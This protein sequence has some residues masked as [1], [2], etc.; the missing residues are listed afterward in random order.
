MAVAELIKK[1][2]EISKDV[3]ATQENLEKV[4]CD[5]Q[6]DEISENTENSNSNEEINT[7][8]CDVDE[9]PTNNISEDLG[10]D[11]KGAEVVENDNKLT[12]EEQNA[13][14][15][16]IK[17]EI[18]NAVAHDSSNVAD[19]FENEN[20]IVTNENNSRIGRDEPFEF[21][22]R[23]LTESS[24][25]WDHNAWDNVEWGEDQVKEAQAKIELQ[26]E[27]PVSDFDKA[28]FNKNPARY[29]DI[30]YKNNKE[31]FFKDRKWLQIEF[32]SLYAATKKD[33][34][35]VTIFEIGCGAGNTFFPI[36]TENENEHLRIIAAD[37]APKAVELVKSSEQ[38]NP[39]YGHAAVWDLA[40][41]DGALPD[42]VEEHS[43][44]IAV[45]IFVF[46]ALAPNQWQQA[47]D[48]L[49][50]VLKPGGK[51]LFRDYGRYDLAQVRFKKNRLLDDN[52]YVRGDGT[53]VYFFTEEE[54]RE[55]FT[56][57]YFIEN[58]IGT[59]RRLL[60]NRKRQLKMYR[61]WLQAVFEVP[62]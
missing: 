3:E 14:A 53:R 4:V 37:F 55:I 23:Q 39:K 9:V 62:E 13:M 44:D 36:L 5:E 57:K 8:N 54:L 31:N 7:F 46:S 43:V 12:T 10:A 19:K 24:D 38:F 6:T 49:K 27:N 35:P 52:F 29:W 18:L 15:Q 30:F 21:G 60:V 2:E 25:V 1:F 34:G 47:L 20:E 11:L 40:N 32:P 45:M 61:C 48:N 41:S 50:K 17:E 42:G 58:K 33:A 28:L 16:D 22:K 56:K 26:Y 51:I 59:D